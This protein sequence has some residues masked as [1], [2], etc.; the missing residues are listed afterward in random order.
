MND[1]KD[2]LNK[3]ID[4]S[5]NYTFEFFGYKTLERSYLIK[6]DDKPVESPQDLFLRV[7]V[8]IHFKQNN[9]D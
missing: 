6:F 9:Q 1:N 2:N 7:A 5:R 3:M 8:S 4:Y